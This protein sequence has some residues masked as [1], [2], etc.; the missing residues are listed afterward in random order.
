MGLRH[1]GGDRA[2]THLRYQLHTNTGRGIGV[3][4]IVNQLGQIFDRVDIV[5]RWWTD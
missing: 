5:V 2:Y 1:T 3:L 4:E